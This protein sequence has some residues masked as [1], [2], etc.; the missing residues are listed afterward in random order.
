MNKKKLR[1]CI[2]LDGTICEIKKPN[3]KYSDVKLKKG[4][5]AQIDSLKEAG[6]T[7]IIHTAR[8]MGSTGHNIGKVIKNVGLITLEWLDKNEIYY[9][10][11]FFGKPNADI[12]I[13]DRVI[14]FEENWS[15]LSEDFLLMY[16]KDK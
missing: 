5:K 4:S 14:R 1:I 6:H 13:D 15:Q 9:D 7:I 10:E 11:I 16:A 8:N 3:Q 2:D 12:T